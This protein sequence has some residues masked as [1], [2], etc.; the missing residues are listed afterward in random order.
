MTAQCPAE[1][2]SRKIPLL[3]SRQKGKAAGFVAVLY[4]YQGHL[5]LT[6]ER[7][8]NELHIRHGD[9]LDVLTLPP[10][11]TRPMVVRRKWSEPPP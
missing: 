6:V 4:P 11:A 5:D 3:V 9:L 1:S 7:K 8:G 10:E 2:G